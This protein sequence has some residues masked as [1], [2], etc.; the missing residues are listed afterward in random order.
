MTPSP[1]ASGAR[2]GVRG[3]PHLSLT[4][5]PLPLLLLLTA[6]TNTPSTGPVEIK[7]DRDACRACGMVISDPHYAAQVRGGPR[8]DVTKF[9]DVGCALK[10]LDT[11]PWADDPK[12]ELWV[13]R[14]TDG[15]FIDGRT[16]RYVPGPPTPMGFNFGAV[17][18]GPT[19]NDLPTQRAQVR[20]AAHTH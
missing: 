7:W 5:L 8:H 20:A 14:R 1:C 18:P 11:Q 4:L 16:A 2:A 12:T 6:C 15:A 19:G 10:W 3:Q 17:D 9:D 13:A